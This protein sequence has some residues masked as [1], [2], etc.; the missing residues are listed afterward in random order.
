MFLK[1]LVIENNTGLI[2][3]IYFRKGLNL[4]VDET[5]NHKEETKDQVDHKSGNNVGKTT[6]L[7]LISYCLGSDGKNIYEDTEFKDNKNTIIRDFLVDTEVVIHLMLVDDLDYPSEEIKIARNFLSRNKKILTINEKQINI[8]DFDLTLKKLIFKSDVEKPTFKQIISKNIR[9]DEKKLA[10]IVKVLNHFTTIEEYEALFLFWLGINTGTHNRKEQLTKNK[11][12]EENY[13]KRLKKEGSLS[14]TEQQLNLVD[15]RIKELEQ[16]KSL[17]NLNEFF[18]EQ[19]VELNRIKSEL[20][21]SSSI[22]SQLHMRRELILESKAE[23]E[24]EKTYIDIQEIELLYKKASKLIPN[25]QV[26]FQDTVKFHN[27]LI[28]EKVEYITLEL[29]TLTT[30]LQ[31]LN[32]KI[33]RLRDREKE[34]SIVINS[35]NY[36]VNYEA[37]LLEFNEKYERRGN[38]SER[39]N[40]WDESNSKLARINTELDDINEG[41]ENKDE[42]IQDRIT[43][44]N[45]YFSKISQALYGEKYLLSSQK[46]DRGYK[47]VVTNFEGNPSTGKKKGQIA[48]FDFAYIQFAEAVDINLLH[49]IMHDQLENI[50]GNQLSTILVDLSNMINCQFVLPI[51]KDKIPVNLDIDD[52]IILSLSED[53]KLFKI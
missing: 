32:D 9:D 53:D 2:R 1:K 19:L 37:I 23:L 4:I 16:Q 28:N 46:D 27:E 41:I 3:E 15:D 42:L 30:N 18:E 24:S 22:L 20:S 47:L 29:P 6:V 10:N 31:G 39:K 35:S 8:K 40:L 43:L 38:L 48:A 25:L 21:K 49:F 36:N 51:I 11:V 33:N 50:H 13:Q 45:Q 34:L 7:R 26:S 14:L 52:F 5:Q 12:K 44:F 17:F